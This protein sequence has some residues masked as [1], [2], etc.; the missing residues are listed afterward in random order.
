MQNHKSVAQNSLVTPPPF[1]EH[2]S[3][4]SVFL[5]PSLSIKM[6]KT[7]ENCPTMPIL[8]ENVIKTAIL[9]RQFPLDT[10]FSSRP[11]R[12]SDRLNIGLI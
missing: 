3:L 2:P 4:L 8:P 6:P 5:A 11:S 9:F 12:T 7:P 1:F 10:P